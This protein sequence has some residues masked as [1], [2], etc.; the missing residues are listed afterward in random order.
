MKA[1]VAVT[2][3]AACVAAQTFDHTTGLRQLLKREHG[4]TGTTGMWKDVFGIG[5]DITFD[6]TTVPINYNT[7]NTV[8]GV[9]ILSLDELIRHPLFQTYY[10][11]PLFRQHFT[12]PTF[13][14]YLTT[15]Y[16]QKFWTHP[17]FPTFFK[18]QY[19]FNKYIFP[20]VYNTVPTTGVNVDS[21]ID[22]DVNTK[23]IF[24]QTVFPL[25]V[26]HVQ[27]TQGMDKIIKTLINKP[28]ILEVLADLK[29]QTPVEEQTFV[30]VV[31][32]IT[33]EIKYTVG[34]YKNVEK[35]VLPVDIFNT[36]RKPVHT[37]NDIELIK[38]AI[39]KKIFL[40]KVIYGD[41]VIPEIYNLEKYESV[42]PRNFVNINKYETVYP[43]DLVN[44]VETVPREIL[45]HYNTLVNKYESVIPR[46]FVNTNKY[47]TII[48]RDFVNTNKYES[49]IPR[50]LVN[51]DLVNKYETVYPRDLVNKYQTVLPREF[52][53]LFNT[54]VQKYET[55][56]PRHL[57][58]KYEIVLPRELIN[59]FETVLPKEFLNHYNTIVNKYAVDTVIPTDL[60][61]KYETILPRELINKYET[62]LPRELVNHYKTL[63]QKY[64]TVLPHLVNNID[65]V[66]PRELVHKYETVLPREF[67]NHYK[68]LVNNIETIP[69]DLETENK[70][71]NILKPIVV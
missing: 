9:N 5:K 26:N 57:L 38:N 52:V 54:L 58:N 35:T 67:L 37:V 27:Y 3:L 66:L 63:V 41:R 64:E 47:E 7:Y 59:K 60:V 42:I 23:N 45:N 62:V 61:N 34:D 10:T 21:E 17:V 65:T 14:V 48:P 44:N 15:P 50:D 18:S 51:R 12:H 25:N 32:P 6:T 30:K 36:I 70:F 49:I 22:L 4:L 40:N 56:L 43:R 55:V 11:L 29:T 69:R 28:E 2:L 31:D 13:Q 19:L 8:N 71:E 16:F 53:Q 33:G 39:L 68:T 20:V 1:F 24:G 46:D